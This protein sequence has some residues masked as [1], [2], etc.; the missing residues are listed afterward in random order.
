MVSTSLLLY[1]HLLSGNFTLY[2]SPVLSDALKLPV[3]LSL[4]EMHDLEVTPA[5]LYH[6]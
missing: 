6:T 3:I 2:L 4:P 5:A 1:Q